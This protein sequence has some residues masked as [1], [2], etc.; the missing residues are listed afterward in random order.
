MTQLEPPFPY[1]GSK[2]AA[3]DLCW[4]AW[5]S[6]VGNFVDMT[7]GTASVLLARPGRDFSTKVETINDA[8]GFI[9]NF[10]RAVSRDPRRVAQFADWPV[11]ELDMHARHAYL[12]KRVD[13]TFIER[14]RDDE[15]FFDPKVAGYWVWGQS[16]WIG[17]GWCDPRKVVARRKLPQLQGAGPANKKHG[18][19]PHP[20]FGRGL[21]RLQLPVPLGD[22]PT[23]RDTLVHYFE[24]LAKRMERVRVVCGPWQRVATPAVTT[25]HGVTAIFMDPPYGSEAK[26]TANLYVVDSLAMAE[27][28]RTWC[29]ERG[30][31]PLLRIVLC[32]Y[33]GEH[34]ELEQHGWRK[35]AWRGKGGFGNQD[36]ENANAE[37]ERLWLSPYCLN[38][39]K[40]PQLSLLD[41]LEERSPLHLY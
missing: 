26:R 36:G 35:V 29:L 22:T 38:K 14:L 17:S 31:N 33:D 8:W 23:R 19:Q 9:P 6:D 25:H 3:A 5:G 15:S 34:N 39:Q 7:C 27:Q 4:E 12:L 41:S 13:A 21:F 16:I 32:G 20:H 37:R 10:W 18:A 40:D 2:A 28:M 30:G 1:F 24:L 11:S